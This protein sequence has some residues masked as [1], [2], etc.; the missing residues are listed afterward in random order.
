[1]GESDSTN[2]RLFRHQ[3]SRVDVDRASIPNDDNSSNLR[4]EQLQ[5]IVQIDVGQH[6]NDQIHALP[7]V[8]CLLFGRV[9]VSYQQ[10]YHVSHSYLLQVSLLLVIE[11]EISAL[12]TYSL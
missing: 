11:S 10:K 7:T 5:V 4:S 2:T 6:F 12:L 8:R 3:Q 9:A 1:M